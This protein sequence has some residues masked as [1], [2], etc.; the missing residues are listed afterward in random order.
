MANKQ[1]DIKLPVWMNKGEPLT[2]AHAAKIWW[3]RVYDWL[4]FPLAQIDVDTCDEQLLDLLAY[5]RD[6][7][8][9]PNEPLSL[10]RLRVKYAF[11]NSQDAGS[12]AGFVQIFKR[13]DIGKIQQ[14]E[15][16]LQYDWDVIVLRINDEQLSRNNDLMMRLVRQ[17]GRTC[18]R[19]FFDVLNHTTE[20]VHSGEFGCISYF[21]HAKLII[22]PTAIVPSKT[23]LWLLPGEETSFTVQVLPT[24][25]EDPTF[26][27]TASNS[28]F[29]TLIREGSTITVKGVDFGQTVITLTTNDGNKTATVTAN[30]VAG[31]K[32]DVLFTSYTQAVFY[33]DKAGTE[34]NLLVDWGDGAIGKNYTR[35]ANGM[36]GFVPLPGTL[37]INQTYT[38]TIY[39]SESVA[40]SYSAISPQSTPN[41]IIRLRQISGKRTNLDYFMYMQKQ[42]TTIDEGAFDYLPNLV[43]LEYTLGLCVN[44][45]QIPSTFLVG[46]TAIENLKGMLYSTNITEVP[47]GFL[48]Q[49]AHLKDVSYMLSY[50]P[51]DHLEPDLMK[52]CANTVE[53]I[54]NMLAYCRMLTSDINAIFSAPTYPKLISTL[55][56]FYWASVT[57]EALPLIKK[58][59]FATQHSSTFSGCRQL[60]DYYQIPSDWV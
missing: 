51:I 14:L 60:Q 47:A 37:E 3:D 15:R 7:E 46:Y 43:S 2:L 40:F 12:V 1:P 18:R 48:Q 52:A 25:A 58:F 8:R 44:L 59:S 26:T 32:V 9:F 31:A 56:A 24:D 20:Y 50:T 34:P 35:L 21:D 23:E 13:L 28:Q 36:G 38:I 54:N 11:V 53:N 45:T 16:Q 5:Q 22:R 17:Y 19:Y 42:L 30:V 10:Y 27:V 57:G 41:R 29:A 33:T 39:N 49:S 4:T 6:I 55:S